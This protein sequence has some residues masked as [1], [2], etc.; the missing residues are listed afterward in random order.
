[1]STLAELM[2]RVRAQASISAEDALEARRAVY[3][4]DAV[5]TQAEA[6]ELLQVDEAADAV[7]PEWTALLVE[8]FCDYAV[9]QKE[10]QGYVD[11]ACADWLVAQLS[12]DGKVK[13]ETELEILVRVLERATSVP[14]RLVTYA[15]E[16]V[17]HA[18]LD[19]EGPLADGGRAERGRVTAGEVALLRRILYASGG[20]DNVGVTRAEAEVLFDINDAARGANNDP[21]WTDLFSRALAASVMAAS[22]YKPVSADEA[23]RRQLWLET[24]TGGVGDLLSRTFSALLSPKRGFTGLR[25]LTETQMQPVMMAERELDSEQITEDEAEWLKSRIMRDGK[26]DAA[27]R[28]VLAFIS[29]EAPAIHPALAP[30]L[31]GAA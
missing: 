11:E 5:L 15:L 16:Q 10:P 27:E 7:S 13:T 1:M 9:N 2:A 22:G 17:K 25:D 29:R 23:M 3:A 19:G 12:R 30:L 26:V 21:S 8:A 28:E 14:Q 18:V 20:D 4:G 24:P 31:E 6:E